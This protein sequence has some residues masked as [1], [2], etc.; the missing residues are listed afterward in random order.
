MRAEPIISD[1][2]VQKYGPRKSYSDQMGRQAHCLQYNSIHTSYIYTNSGSTVVYSFISQIGRTFGQNAVLFR[3]VMLS[4][5][6]V[7][8]R[9][10]Q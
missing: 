6:Y 1:N 9:D 4:Y 3:T 8:G 10:Q 2:Q 7:A 5:F